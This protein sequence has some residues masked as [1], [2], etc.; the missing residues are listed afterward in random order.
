MNAGGTSQLRC[1]LLV[2]VAVSSAWQTLAA[3]TC[4]SNAL[5]QCAVPTACEDLDT[6]L[7]CATAINCQ[8]DP[9]VSQVI[10]DLRE[11]FSTAGGDN[12]NGAPQ[13][14]T[15]NG[16]LYLQAGN[17]IVFQTK[18]ASSNNNDHPVSVT[19]IKGVLSTLPTLASKD[20]VQR[21][22]DTVSDVE[23]ALRTEISTTS[24]VVTDALVPRFSS[25]E[26]A[27]ARSFAAI[28]AS[29]AA[30]WSSL[31]GVNASLTDSIQDVQR[32]VSR[33]AAE[34]SMATGELSQE[35]STL[36]EGVNGVV[37]ELAGK[38][39]DLED[40]TR[41]ANDHISTLLS[42]QEVFEAFRQA[43]SRGLSADAPATTCQEV[44][45]RSDGVFYF[46]SSTGGTFEAFCDLTRDG[47]NWAK[48][49][50]YPGQDFSGWK[51]GSDGSVGNI[52]VGDLVSSFSKLSDAQINSLKSSSSEFRVWKFETACTNNNLYIVTGTSYDDARLDLGLA[53]DGVNV[54]CVARTLE[55][56]D[57]K[58]NNGE[59]RRYN[60]NGD[61]FAFDTYYTN[62][63]D[64]SCNRF[65]IGHVDPSN[66]YTCYP[67]TTNARCVSAGSSCQCGSGSSY[68]PHKDPFPAM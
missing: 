41:Q 67:S 48:V 56:C 4:D 18:T 14:W 28:N 33:A 57:D 53:R 37:G 26:A 40:T 65:F 46:Q 13:M 9:A 12:G 60:G 66:P 36:F 8:S 68:S 17:D 2:L 64:E 10:A 27:I 44:T 20:D 49:L 32:H 35:V 58:W 16:T 51:S 23:G 62:N 3:G 54:Y 29:L 6:F 21:V 1:I 5:L 25:M 34:A 52:A 30:T 19:D 11:C 63:N 39:V 50:Q 43:A 15:A 42:N 38:V 7:A 55:E 47:G 24:E 59:L 31:D 45:S 22:N 61:F